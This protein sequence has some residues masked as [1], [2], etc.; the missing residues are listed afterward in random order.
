MY[1]VSPDDIYRLNPESQKVIRIGDTLKIPQE[2]GSYVYHTIQPK[3]T[4]F[5]LSQ[6]YQ[7]KGEDIIAANPGLSVE[8]FRIGK[9]IR[10]PT[11]KVTTPQQGGNDIADKTNLLLSQVY[12]LKEVNIIKI[13]LLLPFGLKENTNVQNASKNRMVEYYEGFLLALKEMKKAGISIHLQVYDIGS[14]VKEIPS[15]LKKK[16]MQEIHLLIGGLSDE[17]I[18]WLSRFAKENATPYVIP[19]S[20]K[21]NE[22]FNNPNVYQMNTPQ[23][24]LYSK[25]SFAFS[26]KYGKD[27]IILVL[28]DSGTSNQKDFI[29]ILKQDLQEQKIQYKMIKQ[30]PN[31]FN[32]LQ[33][34]LNTNQKNVLLPSDDSAETLSKLTAVSKS[35]IENRPDLSLSLFG[36][37]AW[38]VHSSKYSDDFFRLNTTFYANFYANPT[39]PEIKEFYSLFYKWYLR[40]LENNF[41][42]YGIWGYDTGMYFIQLVHDYGSQFE[43][44]VNDVHY[45]GIQTDFH[46]ER[47]NNWSGFI[48]TNMYLINYNSDYT[49][50]KSQIK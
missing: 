39:S 20:S 17:Q 9:I 2:S 13:A 44:H 15:I 31:F 19:F 50:T 11:N 38:Q 35:I 6:K 18:K 30:G 47:L 22:P 14:D 21:S 4:L 5:A 32:D 23:S 26:S 24:Y 48:N 41:P 33:A 40:M 34:L 36:Y 28:N 29:N 46:F 45:T 27:N 10:I 1:N 49:I 42:K 7:M 16:E 3:E 12:P 43:A 25:A 37:P 8:T